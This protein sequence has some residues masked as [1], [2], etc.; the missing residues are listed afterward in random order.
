MS[1]TDPLEAKKLSKCIVK[2]EMWRRIEEE[3]IS[4]ICFCAALHDNGYFHELINT[5]NS[6]I[7]EAVRGDFEWGSGMGHHET[8][9]TVI[10]KIPGANKMGNIPMCVRRRLFSS[11]SQGSLQSEAQQLSSPTPV[12]LPNQDQISQE[13]VG[14][15]VPVQQSQQS[16]NQIL[17]LH[18]P[19]PQKIQEQNP[20]AH[21]NQTINLSHASGG[22]NCQIQNSQAQLPP[23]SSTTQNHPP[24]NE[25]SQMTTKQNSS[26]QYNRIMNPSYA[27]NVQTCQSRNAQAQIP[28]HASTEQDMHKQNAQ[29]LNVKPLNNYP[30]AFSNHNKQETQIQTNRTENPTPHI[31]LNIP[32]KPTLIQ[33]TQVSSP[34]Q[35]TRSQHAPMETSPIQNYQTQLSS[36]QDTKTHSSTVVSI[37]AENRAKNSNRQNPPNQTL[38]AQNCAQDNS[39]DITTETQ[40]KQHDIINGNEQM[41]VGSTTYL[42]DDI[43]VCHSQYTLVNINRLDNP[44]HQHH[45]HLT[46]VPGE[47]VHN[48]V[49]RVEGVCPSSVAS[50]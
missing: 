17:H 8:T 46:G 11:Q 27:S 31:A 1:T 48:P 24:H 10:E 6:M 37:Q 5:G 39:V 18:N 22:Q 42:K 13:K 44:S 45:Q 9:S 43:L 35:T 29:N 47:W 36:P 50:V 15:T 34:I 26:P 49:S 41:H 30:H 38:N 2:N 12:S 32:T 3:I 28:P 25:P 40:T 33:N 21:D 23:H 20:S 14:Q 16:Q 19:P 7:I 4:D